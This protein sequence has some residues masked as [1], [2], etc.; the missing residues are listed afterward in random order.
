[1]QLLV[2]A[3]DVVPWQ[4]QGLPDWVNSVAYDIVAKVPAGTTL[5]QSNAMLQNL[6]VDRWGLVA[7]T[8]ARPGEIYELT[9]AKG[10][11]KL[12]TGLTEKYDFSMP[13]LFPPRA[14][15]ASATFDNSSSDADLASVLERDL[16]LKLERKKGPVDTLVIDHLEKVPAED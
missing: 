9:V 2:R 1:M 5:K 8:E 4:I 7:H 3:Y 6:L 16:G 14:P 10:G 11:S 12:K 13:L 15:S